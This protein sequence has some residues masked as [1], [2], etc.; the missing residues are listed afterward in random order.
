MIDTGRFLLRDWRKADRAAFV[1]Y[2][3]DP[4]YRA[5]YDLPPG[6]KAAEALFKRFL[7]WQD[8]EPRRSN[9]QFAIVERIEGTPYGGKLLGTAGLR[10][11]EMGGERMGKDEA[12]FGIELAPDQWGRYRLALDVSKAL[13]D[14]GF[15][16]LR[17]QRIYGETA[18]G[19]LKVG[20]LATT[21]GARPH[22]KRDGPAWMQARGWREQVW[23][24]ER[25]N[26]MWSKKNRAAQE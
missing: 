2:Q 15:A 24:L 3:T 7:A 4:R 11:G 1:A 20:K 21:F 14:W 13:V 12:L 25:E 8:E 19:N 17:L 9:W 16:V 6:D 10:R 23:V 5:L 18:T 26:P 22:V